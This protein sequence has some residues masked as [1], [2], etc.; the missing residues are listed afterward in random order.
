MEGS[1]LLP[2]DGSGLRGELRGKET[3]IYGDRTEVETRGPLVRGGK[4]ERRQSPTLTQ[5]DLLG[6][7]ENYHLPV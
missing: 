1:I 2:V 6:W 4:R 7:R 5:S 3:K